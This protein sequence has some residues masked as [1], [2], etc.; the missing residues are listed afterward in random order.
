[1]P[2]LINGVLTPILVWFNLAASVK[3]TGTLWWSEKDERNEPLRMGFGCD[4][5]R[6]FRFFSLPH[7]RDLK[8]SRRGFFMG[9]LRGRSG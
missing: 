7:R 5:Q 1:M 2:W 4:K 8:P 6:L 9:H 3:K